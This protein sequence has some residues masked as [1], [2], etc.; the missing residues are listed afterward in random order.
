MVVGEISQERNLV[1]LGGGP[2]GYSAAIRAVQL[3]LSV[4]LIEKADMGGVCLNR[5][6]IPSKIFS[7]AATRQSEISH[8]QNLGIGIEPTSFNITQLLSYKKRIIEEL[9]TGV[10]NLCKA[11]KIEVI[12]GIGTFLGVNRIGVENGH[13]FDIFQFEQAIIA[14]GSTLESHPMIQENGKRVFSSNEIYDINHVPDHLLIIGSDYI[15]IEVASS[16]AALGAKVTVFL[17]SGTEFPFDESI[18]QELYRLFKKR[19]IIVFKDVELMR[20][21][22]VDDGIIV[23]F[24]K[25]GN[26]TD[27]TGSHLFVSASRKPNVEMLGIDRLGIERTE[28]GFIK[29]NGNMQTSLPSIYAIGDVTEGPML[30]VKA[31]KEGKAAVESIAGEKPEVDLTFIPYVAHTIPPISTAGL[32]EQTARKLEMIVKVSQFNLS[33]NGYAAITGKKEGFIKV[34]SD[35]TTGLL[36]GIHMIG[37][38]AIEMSGSFVQLLEMTAKEEDIKFPAYAHP[39][40]NECLLEAI[41]GLIGQAIHSVPS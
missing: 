31:I 2:G 15:S 14:T 25:A 27:V 26:V 33:G 37:E 3:G 19:K 9:R 20:T 10:E 39:G 8:M 12:R 5:G 23:A 1:I 17:E 16:F 32:T 36:L 29:V 11:N 18:K 6:C 34:I 35:S 22:E 4:T 28:T 40:Y 30:A 13:Q 7:H 41:E 24:Q 21:E 38:G